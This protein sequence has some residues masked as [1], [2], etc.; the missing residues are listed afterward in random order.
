MVN[1]YSQTIYKNVASLSCQVFY[2][3]SSQWTAEPKSCSL[4]QHSAEAKEM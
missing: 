4:I 3:K 1:F 2:V